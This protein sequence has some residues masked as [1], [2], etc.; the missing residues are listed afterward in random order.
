MY[1]KKNKVQKSGGL[2]SVTAPMSTRIKSNFIKPETNKALH[3]L[4]GT[5]AIG[6]WEAWFFLTWQQMGD[7][8]YLLFGY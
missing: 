2:P 4:E 8:D 7:S 3:L 1:G 6:R 5:V